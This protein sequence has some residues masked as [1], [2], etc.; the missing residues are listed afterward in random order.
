[1]ERSVSED[2][3][4]QIRDGIKSVAAQGVCAET[5]WP[6]S[7]ADFPVKPPQACYDEAGGRTVAFSLTILYEKSLGSSLSFTYPYL[8]VI[9]AGVLFPY[10]FHI[11]ISFSRKNLLSLYY[12]KILDNQ[13]RATFQ[14]GIVHVLDCIARRI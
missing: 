12:E 4:A 1:M 8:R 6:Y 3:G 2:S 9:R 13:N 10:I 14:Y 7:D 5:M 11:S